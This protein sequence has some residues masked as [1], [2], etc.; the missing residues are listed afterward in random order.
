MFV[1][2]NTWRARFNT[3]QATFNGAVHP[4]LCRTVHT[5]RKEGTKGL[6]ATRHGMC[7]HDW[8]YVL[9]RF[10]VSHAAG[11]PSSWHGVSHPPPLL[12]CL[13]PSFATAAARRWRYVGVESVGGR[14]AGATWAL[15]SACDDTP[16]TLRGRQKRVRASVELYM[17]DESEG[18]PHRS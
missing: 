15:L 12:E 7:E 9:G 18:A 14:A 10:Y 5:V 13:S 3:L 8:G 11:Q 2:I 6:C 4:S 17:G 1:W 16:L